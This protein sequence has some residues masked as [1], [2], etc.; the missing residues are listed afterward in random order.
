[1]IR[2]VH[3]RSRRAPRALWSD[4]LGLTALEYTV[5]FVIILVA[6]LALWSKLG[7]R[8]AKQVG[9]GTSTLNDALSS[10]QRRGVTELPTNSST[11]LGAGN[12]VVGNALGSP[13]TAV[14]TAPSNGSTMNRPSSSASSGA[15]T[16]AQRRDSASSAS[17]GNVAAQPG[18]GG[19]A[20]TGPAASTS[21]GGAIKPIEVIIPPPSQSE[22]SVLERAGASVVEFGEILADATLGAIAGVTPYGGF[23]PVK[24]PFGHNQ[25]FGQGMMVGSAAG[26]ILDAGAAGGDAL[27][28]TTGVAVPITAPAALGIAAAATGHLGN[29]EQ[30]ANFAMKADEPN[31]TNGETSSTKAGKQIHKERADQRRNSGEWDEVNESIR[32]PDGERI[33]VPRRVDRTGRPID[34]RVQSARPDAVSYKRREILDDKPIGR[35]I[36]KDRQE[37]IRFINAYKEKTG[38]LPRRILIDRYDPATGNTVRIDVYDPLA[39]LPAP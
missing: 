39:F 37:I 20:S 9:D 30:G 17:P 33:E 28:S 29:W 16:T 32:G 19:V 3:E 24:P 21:N 14:T 36:S 27:L 10:A 2:S 18:S 8:M 31:P 26:L 34:D 6:A 12:A 35:D 15:A 22:P 23:L 4:S 11:A 1:M 7:A 13:G 25:A 5:L 38:E